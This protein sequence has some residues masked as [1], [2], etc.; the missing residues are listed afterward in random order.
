MLIEALS[1]HCRYELQGTKWLVGE[2][3]YKVTKYP[4]PDNS[5]TR[6]TNTEVD[7]LIKSAMEIWEEVTNLKF[8]ESNGEALIEI[9]FV[10][11]E[12]GDWDPF[13]GP[14]GQL[15][16]ARFPIYGGHIHMDDE[17]WWTDKSK[18]GVNLLEVLTHELGHS[19]GLK[20]SK[21]KGAVMTAFHDENK[22][23]LKLH[24][25][26]IDAIRSLY[27]KKG[28]GTTSIPGPHT[29]P[30][31][32]PVPK[33]NVTPRPGPNIDPEAELGTCAARVLQSSYSCEMTRN[34]CHGPYYMFTREGDRCGCSCCSGY[35]F[36]C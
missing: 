20:H 12:H 10:K 27:G 5:D 18:S 32:L 17:E 3:T 13:D 11:R 23:D 21:V 28:T 9:S 15:G 26:D 2:L 4:N 33:P 24:Q 19:L 35:S 30:T 31:T 14:G 29:K 22:L 16:H 6:L 25:D 8:R 34:D 1:S 7:A 36:T